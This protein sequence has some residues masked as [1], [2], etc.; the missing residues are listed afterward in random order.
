MSSLIISD[1]I[2]S[3]HQVFLFISVKKI[4]DSGTSTTIFFEVKFVQLFSLLGE[5]LLELCLEV[6]KYR[7]QGEQGRIVALAASKQ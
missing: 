7:V 1:L 5:S 3:N 2:S 6:A 4:K